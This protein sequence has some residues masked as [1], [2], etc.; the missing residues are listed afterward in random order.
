MCYWIDGDGVKRVKDKLQRL[1]GRLFG[2]DEYLDGQHV[3]HEPSWWQSRKT[4]IEAEE[5]LWR[6][7]PPV[8]EITLTPNAPL[9]LQGGATAEP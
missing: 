6:Q 2:Y 7:I 4:R 3:A 8:I 9:H 5:W 1:V